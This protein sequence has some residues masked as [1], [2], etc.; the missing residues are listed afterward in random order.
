MLMLWG[1]PALA[2]NQTA[3]TTIPELPSPE[4]TYRELRHAYQ[5]QNAD[6][7]F[8]LKEFL[9]DFPASE[10]A[11]E[12]RLMLADKYFFEGEYA[13]ALGLYN[14]INENAFSGDTRDGM[15]YRKAYSLIKSGYYDDA[16]TLLWK[17]R[18]SNTF[19]YDARFY[20][21]YIDYAQGNY[22]EAYKAFSALKPGPKAAQADYYLNQID[23]KRGEYRKVANASDRLLVGEIP[24]ELKAET[25]RVSGI[26]YFKIGN[27]TAARKL[28]ENYLAIAGD[29]AEIAALYTL[30]TIYYDEGDYLKALPLF[31]TVTEYPGDLAQ[32]SW[33]YIGQIAMRQGDAQAAAL[34]FDK[35]ARESWDIT[36]AE[37]AAYNLA[38]SNT[39]GMAL[40]FSDAARAME[41]FIATYPASPYAE[42]LSAYLVN[43]Y[44]NRRDYDNALRQAEKLNQNESANRLTR[45]KILYQKG[46]TEFREGKITPAIASLAEAAAGTDRE[47]AAQASLW[48]GD[49]YYVKKEYRNAVRAYNAAI[50]SGSLG[51]NAA[52]AKYNLGY[53]LMKMSDYTKAEKAFK[54]A[55]ALKGLSQ[56]QTADAELRY[57]DCLYYNGKYADA[58]AIFRNIKLGGGQDATFAAIRE[59]DILGRNGNVSEKIR[60]LEQVVENNNDNIWRPT[61]LSRLADAYSEKGDDRKAAALYAQLL[62]NSDNATQKAQT[63][64]SLA[65]N[66][67][68]LLE[69]GDY[70]AALAAYRR[71]ETSGIASLYPDAV[72]GIMRS[73]QTDEEVAEYAAKV[74]RLPGLSPEDTNEAL[75]RG[76]EASL[77]LGAAKRREGLATL[78]TLAASSDRY[79]G[80]KAG[81]LL[82]ETLLEDGDAAGAEETLLHLIDAGSDDN[83]QLALGYIALSDA[84][85]AQGKDY[86]AK[87][88]LETLR[89][90]YPGKEKEISEM[91]TTRLKKIA[92]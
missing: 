47:V 91:I 56:A 24:D 53:A 67:A 84:Y 62:D 9:A 42:T 34:A 50:S 76:A 54:D 18:G 43:A 85:V 17:V 71:L 26:S 78:R 55:L 80:A 32:S 1:V 79:W 6:I 68:N 33:L 5:H 73:S 21:A 90:N 15:L 87:L 25:M 82:G 31:S 8:Q 77:N 75:F 88:Y 61:A 81:V 23:F 66:A 29:G 28:L 44:Y 16:K 41:D 46:L 2:D 35:A 72:T 65:T 40:P 69:E 37:T 22:D 36:V 30:A 45:Q 92:Q 86:L 83:Y 89:D 39:A 70:E 60:I 20:L 14:E 11:A 51:E 38:V 63:Y 12:V 3:E 19:G 13:L 59:A 10:Y 58:L 48:L 4:A 74:L 49:A 27:P 7:I 52:I 57:A 64:Y